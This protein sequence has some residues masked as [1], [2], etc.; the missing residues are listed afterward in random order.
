M[1]RVNVAKLKSIVGEENVRDNVADLYVYGSDSSVHM[2]MPTVVVRPGTKE[3]VQEI[4]R[5]ANT[6][7]VPII[8]RGAGSG[9][10]GHAVPIVGGIVMDLR[11]MNKILE[12]RP[13]DMLCK[14]EPG[15]V[16][17]DLNKALRPYD[18]WFPSP[19]E[20]GRIATI[21]GTIANNGA[22]VR[23][24]KYGTMRDY[25]LGMKVVL[26]NG[27]LVTFGSDTRAQASGYQLDR[28]IVGSEGTLGI[29][30]EATLLLK[31]LP[32]FRAMGIAKF[33]KLE[34]AGEAISEI[35]ASEVTPSLLELV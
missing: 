27:D 6:E 24:V 31:R 7:L 16:I 23:A 25:V 8:A 19:P 13:Q 4:M 20:S 33:D 28:L 9:T 2:A 3:E 14:I 12:I 11:G 18:L 21:G 17:D 22:G 30:V 10:S 5:Y 15:V 1:T 32:K 35:V 26:A 29:I 34:D